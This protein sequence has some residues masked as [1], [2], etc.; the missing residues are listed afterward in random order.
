MVTG[1]V[2][3]VASRIRDGIAAY[4]FLAACVVAAGLRL[5]SL[6]PAIDGP[7]EWRQCDTASYAINFY[8]DGINLFAP[9]INWLGAHKTLILEFPLPEAVVAIVY[10]LFWPSLVFD[11]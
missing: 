7:H 9:G 1:V 10:R 3:A 11:R 5:I 2:R 4:W 8:R 6:S